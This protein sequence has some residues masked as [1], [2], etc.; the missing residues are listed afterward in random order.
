MAETALLRKL[1]GYDASLRSCEDYDL[2]LRL[3]AQ[4][5]VVKRV[6]LPLYFYH[7]NPAGLSRRY[8]DIAQYE[9][10]VV[11]KFLGTSYFGPPDSLQAGSVLGVWLLRHALRAEALDDAVLRE[12][13][14]TN[15]RELL[16]PRWPMLALLVRLARAIRHLRPAS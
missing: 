14:D 16:A 6:R 3:L 8:R 11:R 10:M 7:D 15:V 13:A 9:L 12:Q 1:G 2:W 4:G 5:F